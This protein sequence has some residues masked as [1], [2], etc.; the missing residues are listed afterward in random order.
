M[1]P[2]LEVPTEVNYRRILFCTDFSGNAD[3][4]FHFA[5][6]TAR[7]CTDPELIILHVMPEPEAQFWR[8]YLYEVDDVDKKAADD[9][10]RKIAESYLSA[11][12]EGLRYHVEVLKGKADEQILAYAA[13]IDADLLVMGRHGHR[14]VGLHLF[15]NV[16]ERVACRSLCP[17]LIVP[18]GQK[19]GRRSENQL[20]ASSL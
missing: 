10:N 18:A 6:A 19:Q 2:K 9:M 4:A 5:L 3:Y 14:A 11:I 12:G 16:A 20:H 8:T 13:R 17:V 1:D 7:R 15:G